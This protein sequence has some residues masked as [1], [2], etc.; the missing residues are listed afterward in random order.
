M[1][2]PFLSFGFELA[3]VLELCYNGGA[4]C[5]SLAYITFLALTSANKIPFFFISHWSI[6]TFVDYLSL[7]LQIIADSTFELF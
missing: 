2:R 4:A 5:I 1:D 6:K 3:F 7:L